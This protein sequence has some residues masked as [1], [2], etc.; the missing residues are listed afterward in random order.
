MHVTIEA[1]PVMGGVK[2]LFATG[3]P[4]HIGDQ[5]T[6][7]VLDQADDPPPIEIEVKNGETGRQ[8]KQS[9]PDPLRMGRRSF[10]EIKKDNRFRI[11]ADPDTNT[12]IS[13]AEL[14][15]AKRQAADT[16]RELVAAK[17]AIAGLEE[18]L[19]A[20]RAELEAAKAPPAP[21]AG[22]TPPASPTAPDAPA[23]G[24]KKKG[25]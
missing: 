25:K 1:L 2:F 20:A 11:L 4:F 9:R 19:A 14:E 18:Q 8:E 12:R 15:A 10:E 24:G 23:D 17:A 5:V 3:R 13:A 21:P 7:E 22:E 16:A 6:V